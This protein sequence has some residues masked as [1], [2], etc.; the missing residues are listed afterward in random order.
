MSLIYGLYPNKML[1]EKKAFRALVRNRRKYTYDEVIERVAKRNSGLT[2]AVIKGVLDLFTDE[3]GC[4][5]EEGGSVTTPLFK[6]QCSI[7]GLFDGYDDSFAR[8]RHRVRVSLVAGRFL[9]EMA[10]QVTPRKKGSNIP[11]PSI[12]EFTDMSSGSVNS[13]VT[14]GGPAI[15]K[16]VRLKFQP[17]DPEQGIFFV[18]GDKQFFRASGVFRN[19]FSQLMFL[20]PADMP[21]G[22]Y[23]L[24]VKSKLETRM[25]RTGELRD[26]LV[27]G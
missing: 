26:P 23:Q 1:K 17:D 25:L 14:P 21:S 22:T 20:V 27:A 4:I 8:D 9:K 18:Y 5:L 16:G 11:A 3:V 6:A 19:T 12:V 24:Q 7:A 15:I 2:G 13:V 10:E